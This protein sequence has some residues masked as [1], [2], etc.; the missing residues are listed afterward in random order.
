MLN[1]QGDCSLC[2]HKDIRDHRDHSVACSLRRP[3]NVGYVSSKDVEPGA[4]F[5]GQTVKGWHVT[6]TVPT[7][8]GGRTM[9]T[10]AIEYVSGAFAYGTIVA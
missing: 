4:S 3:P 5:K 1:Q 9:M 8:A 2:G 6:N 7:F 10:I